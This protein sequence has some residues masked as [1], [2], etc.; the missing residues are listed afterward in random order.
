[1]TKNYAI[2][3]LVAA[4]AQDEN[5]AIEGYLNLLEVLEDSSDIAQIE[6]IVSDEKEHAERLADMMKKYD[7]GIEAAE[8]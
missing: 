2:A 3:K 5:E 4:N 7:G 6:E 1:M 8:D